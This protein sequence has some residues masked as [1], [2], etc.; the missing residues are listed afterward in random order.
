[1]AREDEKGTQGDEL[2]GYRLPIN[3][4][5]RNFPPVREEHFVTADSFKQ[6]DP[7]GDTGHK[8]SAR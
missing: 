7:G 4:P 8:V 2:S 5:K 3:K 6:G 1:M